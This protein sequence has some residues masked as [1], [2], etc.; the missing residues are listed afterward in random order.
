MN[1][2]FPEVGQKLQETLLTENVL[3][4][5][6]QRIGLWFGVT[7]YIVTV[8]SDQ[9]ALCTQDVLCQ[10]LWC[11]FSTLSCGLLSSCSYVF[12]QVN[13]SNYSETMERM[14]GPSSVTNLTVVW[15]HSDINVWWHN[16]DTK[17]D[18]PCY[19]NTT[20]TL[21]YNNT[22]TVT[23]IL[24]HHQE[25]T[26]F[27][28][29]VYGDASL[30]LWT[31]SNVS[32]SQHQT[33]YLTYSHNGVKST[34]TNLTCHDVGF[35][36]IVASWDYHAVCPEVTN[37]LIN[38]DYQEDVLANLSTIDITV[39][40]LEHDKYYSMT[41]K[42]V[43]NKGRVFGSSPWASCRTYTT[44]IRNLEVTVI[45]STELDVNWDPPQFVDEVPYYLVRIDGNNYFN[46][47][48]THNT[49]LRL[50]NLREMTEF[51][52][53]VTVAG[54]NHKICD[55]ATTLPS[56]PYGITVVETGK[57]Y[58]SV[59]W[60]YDYNWSGQQF[61]VMWGSDL[62]Y[63]NFTK[64]RWYY[65][66]G[67][68]T[69]DEVVKVCV[70]AMHENLISLNSCAG[71]A[72]PYSSTLAPPITGKSMTWLYVT[73]GIFGSLV[74]VLVVVVVGY[75]NGQQHETQ[76]GAGRRHERALARSRAQ[77]QDNPNPIPLS[78][79]YNKT[80]PQI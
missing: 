30:T 43:D 28:S 37:F 77:G 20:I 46:N 5:S 73:L 40:H 54:Y 47:I 3:E 61:K 15:E 11:N 25:T 22:A 17:I 69:V 29:C 39:T 59:S 70:A 68:N 19:Q 76:A 75:R 74:I 78:L 32:D 52:V 79:Y 57:E 1:N 65:I 23:Q 12:L 50:S 56:S 62:Q 44:V 49:S 26:Q 7:N 2:V 51:T 16:P 72:P 10:E 48:N 66:T 42:T 4:V 58:L 24:P 38:M 45:S 55:V 14:T 67:Y 64:A 60:M 34:V 53:C 13:G 35:D 18:S 9:T 33:Q 80:S 31:Q 36:G 63:S 41:I 8:D 6:W 71:D 21:T 27:P